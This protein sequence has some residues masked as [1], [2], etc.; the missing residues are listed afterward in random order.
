MDDPVGGFKAQA[1]G[2]NTAALDVEK[3][4]FNGSADANGNVEICINV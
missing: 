1:D 3:Y 2:G 4:Q